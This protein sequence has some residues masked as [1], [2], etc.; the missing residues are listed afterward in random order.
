L[1]AIKAF[2]PV[3]RK[4]AYGTG[5]DT[6]TIVPPAAAGASISTVH[7]VDRVARLPQAAGEPVGEHR[8]VFDDE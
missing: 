3:E 6:D 1:R 5:N 8:V 2:R 4:R 7:P